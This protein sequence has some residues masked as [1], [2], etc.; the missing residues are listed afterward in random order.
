MRIKIKDKFYDG[1]DQPI[2]LI[3]TDKDKQHIA[4]MAKDC[5]KFCE[6]PD[7]MDDEKIYKWMN[8]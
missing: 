1:D 8:E 4:N 2:M 7:D 6:Y 5:H 3:L